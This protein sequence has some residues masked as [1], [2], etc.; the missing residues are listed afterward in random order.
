MKD[1]VRV[2][3]IGGSLSPSSSSLAAL[4]IALDGAREAGAETELFDIRVLNLPMYSPT[5][6][7]IPPSVSRYCDAVYGADVTLASL[8]LC[9]E[10]L[11][12]VRH[13]LAGP[14]QDLLPH[15]LARFIRR[16]ELTQ[17]FSVPSTMT[18]MAKN[19]A[20]PPGGFETLEREIW[21]GEVLPTPVLVHWM[22]RVPNARFTNLYGPTETT[23][24]SSYY[25]VARS[26]SDETE[27]IPIGQP[28]AGE[29]LLILDE[30]LMPVREGEIGELVLTTLTKEALPMLRYRTR[31]ITRLIDEPCACGRTTPRIAIHGR[32]DD[33]MRVRA[34]NV[35]TNTPPRTQQ[36][37]PGPM[38]ANGIIEPAITKAAAKLGIDQVELD[39]L[40]ADRRLHG[41]GLNARP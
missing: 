29:E 24:A 6:A 20:V 38:Q 16:S 1:Q 27:P 21:C 12:G 35:L 28:C 10:T 32:R 11:D 7:E 33:M 30:D 3:G 5:A 31:D 14:V 8:N 19:R 2:V 36:R 37:S 25:T 22:Q 26:P 17:W 13:L 39:I 23:I 41:G 18:Y 34:V 9:L 40:A 4:K 15:E